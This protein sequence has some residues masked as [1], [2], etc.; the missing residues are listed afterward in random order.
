M[1]QK[2]VNSI[3]KVTGCVFILFGF[4]MLCIGVPF[5]F[6]NNRGNIED[7]IMS[8]SIISG[9]LM[10]FGG[11][12]NI[13]KAKLKD[14]A[15]KEYEEEIQLQL[16]STKNKISSTHIKPEEIYKPDILATWNYTKEEWKLMTK[17]ETTRRLKEGIW[18]SLS[19]GLLAGYILYRYKDTTFLFGFLFSLCIGIFISLVKVLI[20]NNLMMLRKSNSIIITTNVLIINGKFK[21]ISDNDINLEYIKILKINAN[22]FMEFSLQW[23]T[24]RGLTNDQMRILVPYK[25]QN[26]IEKV[27]D[28]YKAKGVKI[29]ELI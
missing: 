22:I 6:E 7:I 17:E 14:K 28:Y 27:L 8:L 1:D 21:T 2:Q 24:R 3:S 5:I 20:S 16:N 15:V 25:Y 11:Y 12:Q 23:L 19:V 10:I 13:N 4:A 18:V 9:V 26:E 29:E